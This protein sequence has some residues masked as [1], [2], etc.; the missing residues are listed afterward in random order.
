[1]RRRMLRP[2]Y[3]HTNSSEPMNA[4]APIAIITMIA[5][6]VR[7]NAFS[8]VSAVLVCTLADEFLHTHGEERIEPVR[9]V[10]DALAGVD[11]LQLLAAQVED[12]VAALA[13]RDQLGRALLDQ[14]G[15]EQLAHDLDVVE[16]ASSCVALNVFS[17]SSIALLRVAAA[18]ALSAPAIRLKSDM[19]VGERVGH[20]H[21]GERF[22]QRALRHR[23]PS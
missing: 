15:G 23:P 6:D 12:A 11:D 3:S 1:M 5:N 16:H 14:R 9:V 19:Q 8:D 18:A 20:P 7:L 22:L 4:A 10:E 13:E 21:G 17:A 2:T